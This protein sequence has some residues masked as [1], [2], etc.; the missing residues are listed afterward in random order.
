MK[1]RHARHLRWT[2]LAVAL[3]VLGP[4]A[5]W[6]QTT[7]ASATTTAAPSNALD[8]LIAQ[9]TPWAGSPENAKSLVQGLNTG[10]SVTLASKPG[11]APSATTAPN[12]TFTPATPKL[13]VG[14]VNIALSLAKASL[15]QLGITKPTPAQLSAA[16]NGGTVTS[17][18]ATTSLPGVLA[19][20][21]AGS[22]WGEIAKTM[23]V[24]LG[25]VVSASKTGKE[26]HAKNSHAK[27]GHADSG[28][29]LHASHGGSDSHGNSGH[30]GG[31]SGGGGSGG[32]KSK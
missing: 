4:A 26:H 32:G 23:G 13:G 10:S 1:N 24:K 30:G 11:S 27:S 7:S 6:A 9:Y 20:R 28:G 25:A 22:G 2:L 17:A 14:E 8:K 3:G 5:A 18:T 21:Q 29:K 31:N 15:S 19:Q 12:A 16:L